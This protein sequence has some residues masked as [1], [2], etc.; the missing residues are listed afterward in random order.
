MMLVY[1]YEAIDFAATNGMG[2]ISVES[3]RLVWHH[4]CGTGNTNALLV[5]SWS[6]ISIDDTLF[7]PMVV[8]NKRHTGTICSTKALHLPYP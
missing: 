1:A 5:I 8:L 3:E 2:V 4:V 6:F 7:Q